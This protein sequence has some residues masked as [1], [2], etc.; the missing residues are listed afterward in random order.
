[1]RTSPLTLER[2]VDCPCCGAGISVIVDLSQGGADYVED[3]EVCCQPMRVAYGTDAAEL[4][5][6]RVERLDL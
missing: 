2:P 4:A 3:C 5:W 6:L 1:M